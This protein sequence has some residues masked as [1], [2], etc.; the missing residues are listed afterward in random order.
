M[1]RY[2]RNRQVSS[3][4]GIESAVWASTG[5]IDTETDSLLITIQTFTADRMDSDIAS[6][7]SYPAWLNVWNGFAQDFAQWRDSAWFWNP[8]RRDQLLEYR[9]RFNE[10]LASY[11]SLGPSATTGLSPLAHDRPEPDSLDKL[12]K[13]AKWG[14]GILIVGGIIKVAVDTGA[15]N[16]L[17]RK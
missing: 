16:F 14:I 12:M 2:R 17:R 7:P 1:T 10:L 3:L 15:L 6:H 11:K 13:V 9:R 8:T 5:D 4:S